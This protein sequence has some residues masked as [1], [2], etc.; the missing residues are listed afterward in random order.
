ML[1]ASQLQHCAY[2][3]AK[4]PATSNP[5]NE[6]IQFK[7]RFAKTQNIVVVL[8]L[9]VYIIV[10]RVV[11]RFGV[12]V[13]LIQKQILRYL[14]LFALLRSHLAQVCSWHFGIHDTA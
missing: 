10:Y 2:A 13:I 12:V 7:G 11:I 3:Q 1:R 6:M 4:A 5:P 8:C 14:C 9:T